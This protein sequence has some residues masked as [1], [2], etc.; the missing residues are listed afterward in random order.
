MSNLQIEFKIDCEF[1]LPIDYNF[2]FEIDYK[3]T[4]NLFI[5]LNSIQEV[6]K[7]KKME[8][9]NQKN[10]LDLYYEYEKDSNWEFVDTRF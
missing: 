9:S 5:K 3:S 7:G 1:Q 4:N 8:F 6:V 10:I 2:S